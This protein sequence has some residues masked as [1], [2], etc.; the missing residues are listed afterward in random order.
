LSEN[1]ELLPALVVEDDPQ[2]VE[3]FTLS[4]IDAGFAVVSIMDGEEAS[5]WLQ[6]AVPAL[7]VLDLHLP[8]ASGG[9]LLEQIRKDPRL[10]NTKVVISTADPN[11]AETFED[12]AD[13][14]L[15]KPVSFRQLS[16]LTQRL[17][18]TLLS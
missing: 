5:R 12:E 11:W 7:V 13:L 17:K 18:T 2:L 15:I 1:E 8:N 14:I 10:V 9:S 3:I 4:L 16:V 6:T